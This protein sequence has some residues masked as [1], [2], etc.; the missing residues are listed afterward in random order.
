LNR[1]NIKR[2]IMEDPLFFVSLEGDKYRDIFYDIFARCLLI[3]I[4]R[5]RSVSSE[6]DVWVLVTNGSRS[7]ECKYDISKSYDKWPVELGGSSLESSQE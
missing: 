4:T 5:N 1:A 2:K 7:I 6:R 3:I